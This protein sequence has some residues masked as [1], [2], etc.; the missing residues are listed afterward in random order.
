MK[1]IDKTC[2]VCGQHFQVPLCHSDRYITCGYTCGGI[3]R[4]KE[5]IV[6]SCLHCSIDFISKKAP[7]KKQ[8]FCSRKCALSS[9]KN[10]IERTCQECQNK[11][12]VVP[13]RLKSG[14]NRATFCSR[15]CQLKKWNRESLKSQ[16][17]TSYRRNAWRVFEKKCY[18]CGFIDERVLVIHHIDGN[19]D[20]G[21]I[22]NLIPVCH[23]CHCLRHIIMNG[24]HR[25]PS[26]RGKD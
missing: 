1:K 23:N 11:F 2:P 3:Y 12:D 9:R 24:N 21:N 5:R 26:Y 6:N 15:I 10:R 13:Y 18:D 20:N 19:R 25:I 17:P 4:K 22:S 8:D 7:T 14:G 16:K